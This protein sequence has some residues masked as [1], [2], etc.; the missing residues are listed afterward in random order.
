MWQVAE[1]EQNEEHILSKNYKG[2]KDFSFHSSVI[3]NSKV[4]NKMG[5]S[6][7]EHTW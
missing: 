5:F 1:E 3:L 7:A 4:R 6:I 2:K